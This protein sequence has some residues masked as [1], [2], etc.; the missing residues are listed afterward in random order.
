[1]VGGV[2]VVENVFSWPGIGTTLVSS[3]LARDYPMVQGIILLLG[4]LVLVVNTVVDVLLALLNPRT[5]AGKA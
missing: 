1:M 2:V 4:L 3:I 5:L